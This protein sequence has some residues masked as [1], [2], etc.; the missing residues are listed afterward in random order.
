MAI[1][2][3]DGKIHSLEAHSLPNHELISSS[4]IGG[5]KFQSKKAMEDRKKNNEDTRTMDYAG[6]TENDIKISAALEDVAKEHGLESPA[7]IA[8]AYIMSKVPY[9]FPII[10]GRK[11]EHLEANIKALEIKL[12][13]K[14]IEYLESVVPFE[15]GFPQ[16]FVG[17]DPA[18][19]GKSP[20]LVE[21]AA[22]MSWV[23][24][25]KPIGHE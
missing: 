2:P 18:V 9:V 17:D 4:V 7:T 22:Q 19:S 25:S 23:L 13:T 12:T 8:L 16:N 20:P 24:G 14:Q 5:G 11:I 6:Q 15:Q 1:A 21:T 10:G 3:W